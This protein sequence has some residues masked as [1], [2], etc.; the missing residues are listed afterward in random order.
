MKTQQLSAETLKK[1]LSYSKAAAGLLVIGERVNA[2]IVYTNVDPDVT[3]L[4]N[5]YYPIDFDGANDY[6]FRLFASYYSGW[7]YVGLTNFQ[8]SFQFAAW[9][10]YVYYARPLAANYLIDNTRTFQNIQ[11]K[12]AGLWDFYHYY[13]STDRYLGCRFKISSSWHYG[14]VR[15]NVGSF[16]I[17]IKDYAYNT[18]ANQGIQTGQTTGL[19]PDN[20]LEGLDIWPTPAKDVIYLS[21]LKAINKVDVYD[22]SGAC[23]MSKIFENGQPELDVSALKNGMY[24]VK[25]YTPDG[26]SVHKIVKE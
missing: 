7:T 18:T 12:W 10:S 25:V 6:E 24:I 14:W 11:N 1:V 20:E 9:A 19:E 23:V 8:N 16:G 5:E 2:Q 22:L 15:L 26:L 13:G 21:Y 4:D 17:T 3:I